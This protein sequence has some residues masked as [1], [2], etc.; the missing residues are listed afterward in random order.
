MH[1][2]SIANRHTSAERL[3]ATYPDAR[4]F[5]VTSGGPRRWV[6][7]SPFYSHG[8]IFVVLLDYETNSDFDKLAKP[9][10]H[11][12]LIMRYLAQQWPDAS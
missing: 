9:L 2:I 5:D 4:I 3:V 10:S 8:T 6:K 7:C 1:A 12:A 11:A